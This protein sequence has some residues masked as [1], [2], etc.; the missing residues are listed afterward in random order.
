MVA[1]KTEKGNN[2]QKIVLSI[3]IGAFLLGTVSF[4][5]VSNLRI[6]QRRAE[7][8]GKIDF[9]KQEIEALEEKNNQLEAGIGQTGSDT[10]WEE[11]IREQGYKKPGEESVVVLPPE[12]GEGEIEEEKS[13]WQRFLKKIG[14]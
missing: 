12:G 10:Y 14:F 11:R 9:L 8:I 1:K 4:F 3:L 13:I 2:F 6:S 7:L 5:V